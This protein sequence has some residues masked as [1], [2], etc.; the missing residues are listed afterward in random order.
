MFLISSAKIVTRGGNVQQS[1][2]AKEHLE[3]YFKMYHKTDTLTSTL[4][5]FARVTKICQDYEEMK[6][7]RVHKANVPF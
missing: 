2:D 4:R 3:D 7:C 1:A 5:I 6:L